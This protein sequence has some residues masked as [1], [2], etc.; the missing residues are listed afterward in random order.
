MAKSRNGVITRIVGGVAT[1]IAVATI[2]FIVASAKSIESNTHAAEMNSTQINQVD[3][4]V[5]AL[6]MK[7]EAF[8]TSTTKVVGQIQTSVAV[9]E[10]QL[11][12]HNEHHNP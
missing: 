8:I 3:K 4:K 9:I 7:Q 11:K 10:V 5:D 12:V 1:A 2:F 6:I